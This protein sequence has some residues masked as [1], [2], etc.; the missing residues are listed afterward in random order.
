MWA[1]PM[2]AGSD[3]QCFLSPNCEKIVIEYYQNPETFPKSMG[4]SKKKLFEMSDYCK[5]AAECVSKDIFQ[6][7]CLFAPESKVFSEKS[8]VFFLETLSYF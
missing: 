6:K 1:Y 2:N 4:V 5:F 8:I 3:R 7:N